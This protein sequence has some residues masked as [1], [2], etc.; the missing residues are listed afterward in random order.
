MDIDFGYNGEGNAADGNSLNG[1]G[2]Q[3]NI[4]NIDNGN[5]EH[6]PNGVPAEDI[7]EGNEGNEGND[8]KP[9]ETTT[10]PHDLE[11]G[12]SIEVE[13]KTYTV[14]ENG[15]ILDENGSVFKKADE[16]KDWLNTFEQEN[17]NDDNEE[18]NINSIQNIFG[19]EVTDEN[20]KKIEFE[21]SPAGV[22]AYLDAVLETK[23][24]EHYETAI[25]TLYQKYP[26]VNDVINYYVTNGNSLKGFNEIPDRSTITIDDSNEAQQE[27]IIKMAWA[28]R[29]QKGDVNHYL[30]YLKSSGTL[31][32][33]AQEELE[34][35]KEADKA[36][37]AE[38]E[39][40][41]ERIERANYEEN[42]KFWNSVYETIKGK[43]LAGYAIPDTII[44]NRNGQKISATPQD[45]FNYVYA[46]DN[47][48]K[49]AYMKDLE[50]ETPESRRDDE[51]LRAY[52]KF[53]GGT[54]SN[55]VDMA[56]NAEKVNKLKLKAK[57]TTKSSVRISKPTSA[58]KKGV[59]LDLGYE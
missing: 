51:L 55:L 59:K 57:Q 7:T 27:Y 2:N 1:N 38:L 26:F 53:T 15:D 48:G 19:I 41:A 54:Y 46:V 56:I 30:N 13:D 34:A 39:A 21:N 35:L 37:K 17:D 22:K 49:S 52:L 31:L 43:K 5:I 24:D 23:R 25:N 3:E 58:P 4:T 20:D 33:V 18:I 45:F 9:S 16:V 10:K 12:T 32:A 47:N 50:K 8:N 29:N 28:E 6:E 40:E 36:Y 42:A 11:V 44:I 14:G